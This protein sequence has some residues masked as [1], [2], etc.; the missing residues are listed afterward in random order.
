MWVS[1]VP[2]LQVGINSAILLGNEN[3]DLIVQPF[4]VNDAFIK[5]LQMTTF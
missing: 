5:Y 3:I 4:S 1:T 2:T